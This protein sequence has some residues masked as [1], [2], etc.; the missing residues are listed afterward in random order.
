[1]SAVFWKE[2]EH[3]NNG[4]NESKKK[5]TKAPPNSAAPGSTNLLHSISLGK[6]A[7][8]LWTSAKGKI[9]I[10]DDLLKEVS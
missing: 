5:K 8:A 1:V 6:G 3:T 4:E 7:T 10:I 2:K 9:N